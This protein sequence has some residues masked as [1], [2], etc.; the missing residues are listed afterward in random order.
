MLPVSAISQSMRC[1]P[2][3]SN[4]FRVSLTALLPSS[5]SFICPPPHPCQSAYRGSPVSNHGAGSLICSVHGIDV[6]RFTASQQSWGLNSCCILLILC[7]H[8]SVSRWSDSLFLIQVSEITKS[9]CQSLCCILKWDCTLS[10]HWNIRCYY[11]WLR[12][13]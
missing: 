12:S 10:T 7:K 4:T 8:I 9:Q 11:F 3:Q 1:P 2:L 5:S 13:N 6:V